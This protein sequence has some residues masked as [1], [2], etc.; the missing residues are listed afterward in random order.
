MVVGT[1]VVVLARRVVQGALEVCVAGVFH[2]VH[3]RVQFPV[4][5]GMFFAFLGIPGEDIHD[6]HRHLAH[7]GRG[8]EGFRRCSPVDEGGGLFVGSRGGQVPVSAAE[9]RGCVPRPHQHPGMHAWPQ[10]MQAERKRGGDAE[11]PAAAVQG[12]E[13]F[14]ILLGAG[15]HLLAGGRDQIHGDEVVAGEAE[16]ALEPAGPAPER[17]TR[18]PGRG[19]PPA[20]DGEAVFLGGAVKLAAGEARAHRGSA[21]L[22]VHPDGLHRTNVDHEAAVVHG[23][24]GYGMA[25]GPDGDFEAVCPRVRQR[26]GHPYRVGA[27]GNDGRMAVDH[28]VEESSCFVVLRVTRPDPPHGSAPSVTAAP[29]HFSSLRLHASC[30][31]GSLLSQPRTARCS[32]AGGCPPGVLVR[33]AGGSE[34][35]V[36]RGRRGPGAG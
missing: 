15:P 7:H 28:R 30:G 22:R 13:E 12:P 27:R 11:V 5:P 4:C 14:G 24:A 17:E 33:A 18:E 32:G 10:L 8:H 21:G 36:S 2:Q 1:P 16:G 31:Y 9:F 6:V 35:W 3:N 20:C 23:H 25:A 29:P 26:L 34:R 19:D